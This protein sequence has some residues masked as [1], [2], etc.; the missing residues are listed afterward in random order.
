MNAC[1]LCLVFACGTCCLLTFP[2]PA[3][4]RFLQVDPVGYQDQ[5]NLYA[6]VQNDPINNA[7]PTGRTCENQ[8]KWACRIDHVDRSALTPAQQKGVARIEA[9][10]SAVVND[11]VSMPDRSVLVAPSATDPETGTPQGA[12]E[13]N[14]R[15]AANNLIGRT[16]SY[17]PGDTGRDSNHTAY[18]EGSVGQNGTGTV[19]THLTDR[20]LE[21]GNTITLVHEGSLHGSRQEY[22]GGLISPAGSQLGTPPYSA[23]HQMPYR[24]AACQLV[25]KCQ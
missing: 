25:G 19:I 3:N 9:A 11:L 16:F 2:A 8:G 21:R 22:G 5:H 23:G 15:D 12:F 14:R 20:G 10:Y 7:D 18:T 13:I 24:E 1:K 4:A 6:Y 17:R